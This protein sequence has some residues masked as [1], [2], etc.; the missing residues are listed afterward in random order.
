[1]I[2]SAIDELRKNNMIPEIGGIPEYVWETED[3]SSLARP[4]SFI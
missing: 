3:K 1:M 4:G 2:N